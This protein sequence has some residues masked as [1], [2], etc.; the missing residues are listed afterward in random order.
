MKI[1]CIIVDDEPLARE[2][3]R[4]YVERVSFLQF[5]GE[6]KG[7]KEAGAF[8]DEHPVDLM[9]L[10][11]NMPK[12]SGLEFL[13]NLEQPPLVIFTTAYREFASDS[14]DLDGLDYLVKPIAFERFYKAVNK[15]Y[16]HFES[17]QSAEDDVF[18][19]KVD[20]VITKVDRAEVLYI[21]GMKDYIKIYLK[22]GKR[23]ITL[24]SLKQVEN[25]LPA[26]QF[27]RVHRSFIIAKNQVDSIE[28]NTL[29]IKGKQIPMAPNLRAEVLENIVG[30]KFWKRS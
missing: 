15:V 25:L 24:L 12:Q 13:R 27:L 9:F 30:D 5:M 6:F 29:H 19:V 8:L 7:A 16:Q 22:N 11:I 1:N 2:G 20:G 10:D 26:Q 3:I 17:A 23:L 28:G 14:Y 21:E 18:Y 4:D